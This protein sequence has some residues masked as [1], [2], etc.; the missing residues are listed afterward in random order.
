MVSTHVGWFFAL[1]KTKWRWSLWSYIKQSIHLYERYELQTE[2]QWL[3]QKKQ[4]Q[5]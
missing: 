4:T 5:N 1:T 2:P 3:P